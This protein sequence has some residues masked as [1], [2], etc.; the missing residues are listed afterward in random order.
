MAAP[1]SILAWGGLGTEGPG[2]SHSLTRLNDSATATPSI[3]TLL[4]VF[5]MHV[6]ISCIFFSS[7]FFNAW[8]FLLT[9][10]HHPDFPPGGFHIYLFARFPGDVPAAWLVFSLKS[11]LI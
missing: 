4:E 7:F 6:L 9:E 11:S 5:S 10:C 3:S 8:N 2:G 1:S